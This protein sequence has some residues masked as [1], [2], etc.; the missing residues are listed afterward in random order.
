MRAAPE[1]K[2]GGMSFRQS[3][4][5]AFSVFEQGHS[6]PVQGQVRIEERVIVRISPSTP[7]SRQAMLADL[8]R[9][10][11][12]TRYQEEPLR[13]CIPIGAIAGVQPLAQ[14]SRLLLFM[15]DR[16]ILSA[17]LERTCSV[18]AFY[19]GFYVERNQDGMLCASRDLLQSR[20]GAKCEVAQLNRLVAIRD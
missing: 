18:Q 6:T 14:E 15:R 16:R 13:G 1:E 3:R 10:S 5:E 17:A 7:A 8:P 20:A 4:P 11:I 19:S 9:R 2:L 12:S